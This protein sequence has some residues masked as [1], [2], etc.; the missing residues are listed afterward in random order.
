MWSSNGFGCRRKPPTF[1]VHYYVLF[2]CLFVFCFFFHLR[3]QL[4][5]LENLVTS[6]FPITCYF[7][8]SH[9][10][11]SF[12]TNEE[13]SLLRAL[14]LLSRCGVW[15]LFTPTSLPG[16]TLL[17]R[18]VTWLSKSGSQNRTI[19]LNGEVVKHKNGRCCVRK[20]HNQH[21][22]LT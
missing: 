8:L 15:A 18:L 14:F 17:P 19:N 22:L 16:F 6:Y 2:V 20:T 3:S 5:R 21:R 12:I 7:Q 1:Y 9:F 11:S 10:S 4:S 13:K